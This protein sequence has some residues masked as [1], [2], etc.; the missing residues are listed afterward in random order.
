VWF[1]NAVIT[2]L[3]DDMLSRYDVERTQALLEAMQTIAEDTEL[4]IITPE[5]ADHNIAQLWA[6]FQQVKKEVSA[7]Q[8]RRKKRKM[9]YRIMLL[10]VGCLLAAICCLA[11]FML[12]D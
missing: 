9:R 11:F 6:E 2:Q 10:C 3:S 4:G 7:E 1:L 8:L 5:Q 12:P